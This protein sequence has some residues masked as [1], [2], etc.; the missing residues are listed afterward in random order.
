MYTLEVF[1]NGVLEHIERHSNA[2]AVLLRMRTLLEEHGGC[3]KIIVRFG[4]TRLF[5]VDCKGNRLP[6]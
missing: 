5:A 6:D 3:E 4:S 2:A 1:Y